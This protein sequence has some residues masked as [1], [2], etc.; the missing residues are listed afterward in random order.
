MPQLN[1]NNGMYGLL[2]NFMGKSCERI[3]FDV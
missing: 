1:V 3:S 2:Q